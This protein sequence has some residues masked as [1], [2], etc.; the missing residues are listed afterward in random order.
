MFSISSNNCLIGILHI[1]QQPVRFFLQLGKV[2][3]L[4][5]DSQNTAAMVWCTVGVTPLMASAFPVVQ[6]FSNIRLLLVVTGVLQEF[7][8]EEF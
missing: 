5:N 8:Q 4:V 1:S 3:L 7:F 6:M 2:T